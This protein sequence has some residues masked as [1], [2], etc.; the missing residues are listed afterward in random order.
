MNSKFKRG[1][2]VLVVKPGDAH[3]GSVLVIHHITI[4]DD[5]NPDEQSVTYTLYGD[6]G[7][8]G[9]FDE[10][11][12]IADPEEIR[13]VYVGMADAAIAA[14]DPPKKIKEKSPNDMLKDE[15]KK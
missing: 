10:S 14:I 3:D 12:L 2:K 5:E 4:E 7:L 6:N 1:N 11:V 9:R 13:K 8:V 15:R